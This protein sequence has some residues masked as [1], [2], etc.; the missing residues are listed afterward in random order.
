MT[1]YQVL[2]IICTISFFVF[3]NQVNSLAEQ[4]CRALI[5]SSRSLSS[6][7]CVLKQY[8]SFMFIFFG[9]L[10]SAATAL[11]QVC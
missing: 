2:L 10:S 3:F 1:T 9:R 11:R 5:K 8:F 6:H 4:T 7:V